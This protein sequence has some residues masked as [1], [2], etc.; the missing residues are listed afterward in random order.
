[1]KII[2]FG[3]TGDLGKLIVEQAL[4]QGHEVTVFVRTPALF[5]MVDLH[6]TIIQGDV[7]DAARV[8]VAV[9]GHEAVISALGVKLG[10]PPERIRSEGTQN[11]VTAMEHHGVKR[12]ICV[13]AMGAGDSKSR[14]GLFGKVLV[15]LIA[16]ERF[17]DV[18]RQEQIIQNSH[19]N[20][21]LVRPPR[22]TNGPKTGAYRTGIDLKTGMSSKVSR[23]DVAD[24]LLK[25]VSDDTHLHQALTI[26]S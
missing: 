14:S 11:I 23:A 15:P 21:V 1:M 8:E 12:L 5:T 7:L 3:A 17:A 19:L 6:L 16:K 9:T 26:T 10:R 13:S 2:I 20:W 24:F 25:Q 18:E 22:L 4:A